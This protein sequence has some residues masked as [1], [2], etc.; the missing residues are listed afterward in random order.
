MWELHG[1]GCGFSWFLMCF[2]VCSSRNVLRAN[3]IPCD[4]FRMKVMGVPVVAIM[5][6]DR[7][8]LWFVFVDCVRVVSSSS[9]GCVREDLRKG[10]R[11]GKKVGGVERKHGED[12]RKALRIL[13]K[14]GELG[15][16][17]ETFHVEKVGG[18]GKKVGDLARGKS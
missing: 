9:S 11:F 13:E 1:N 17:L 4:L 12:M 10:L 3:V 7:P 16:K 2:V 5:Y 14:V 8:R 15:R 6:S 18:F